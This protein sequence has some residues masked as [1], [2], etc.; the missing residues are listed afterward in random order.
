MDAPWQ[1]FERCL[2]QCLTM[3][4][5]PEILPPPPPPVK[6][7]KSTEITVSTL[8]ESYARHCV[9]CAADYLPSYASALLRI[10][11]V[12]PRGECAADSS[13]ARPPPP[14][15]EFKVAT[16]PSFELVESVVLDGNTGERLTH[17]VVKRGS[18][19]LE[20]LRFR[21]HAPIGRL[22]RT[23]TTAMRIMGMWQV[24]SRQTLEMGEYAPHGRVHEFEMPRAEIPTSSFAAGRF[25]CDVEY[26]ADGVAGVLRKEE[27]IEFS[28]V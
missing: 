19:R 9:A 6:A 10:G 27:D 14:S 22:R 24:V 2:K 15:L 11:E 26:S 25:R 7:A 12:T 17:A 4:G 20:T 21:V 3:P 23:T 16:H 5:R 13:S 8:Y 18:T 1:P 28:I